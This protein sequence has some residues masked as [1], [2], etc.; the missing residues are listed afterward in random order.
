MGEELGDAIKGVFLTG[1]VIPRW[2]TFN[3]DTCYGFYTRWMCFVSR[4]G[5]LRRYSEY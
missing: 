3:E 1:G 2:G 4:G 5:W